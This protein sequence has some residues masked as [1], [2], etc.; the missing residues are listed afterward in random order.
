MAL[1]ITFN[2]ENPP[3]KKFRAAELGL[4]PDGIEQLYPFSGKEATPLWIDDDGAGV[5]PG[6]EIAGGHGA[7]AV[8]A[9]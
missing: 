8:G 1:W 4:P 5:G 7:I 2:H 6:L 9:G 3:L